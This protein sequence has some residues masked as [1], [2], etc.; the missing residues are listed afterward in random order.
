MTTD[1]DPRPEFV[2]VIRVRVPHAALDQHPD[3]PQRQSAGLAVMAALR[4]AGVLLV[5]CHTRR[6]TDT[7]ERPVCLC[8]NHSEEHPR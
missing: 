8:P 3:R 2:M 7:I 1:P 4:D 5:E 6:L